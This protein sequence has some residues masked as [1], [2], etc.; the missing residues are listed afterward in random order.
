MRFKVQILG[1]G[2]ALPTRTRMPSAQWVEIQNVFILLDCAEGTQ[3]QLRK[4]GLN[5]QKI[6]IIAITHLHG[7]HYFGLIGL[8]SSMSLL[9]RKKTLTL[10]GPPG[11]D[12]IIYQQFNRSKSKLHFQLDF[13]PTQMNEPQVVFE[14]AKFS[15]S[16]VPLNHNIHCTGFILKEKDKPRKINGQRCKEL[17]VPV[18]LMNDLK[19][20]K[21]ITWEEGSYNNKMLTFDPPKSYTYAYITDTKCSEDI[22]PFIN[23][24]DLLY[25]ETTFLTKDVKRAEKTFHSISTEVAQLAHKAKVGHLIC[26]HYSAKYLEPEVLFKAEI[27]PIFKNV[28][29]AFDGFFLDLY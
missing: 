20:G 24:I 13:I 14:S 11:L 23:E 3:F 6:D 4:F 5:I 29:C 2:S 25:H 8:I 9:G 28:S 16:T 27:E 21:D 12:E 15:I 26:G 10:I 7:D 17:N 18:F 1:S 19:E 22:L